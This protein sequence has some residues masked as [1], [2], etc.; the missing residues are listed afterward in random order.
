[1]GTGG[2]LAVMAVAFGG[3]GAFWA[4]RALCE[5]ARRRAQLASALATADEPPFAPLL[6]RG[7][8]PLVPLARRLLEVPGL[9]RAFEP[10]R[11]LAGA[12]GVDAD[13]A[14]LLSCLMAAMAVAGAA[15]GVV[16]ASPV[17]G[18]AVACCVAIAP[19][20][21][22]RTAA[23]RRALAMREEVPEA[24]RA[25]AVCFR[26]GL[27]LV[28]TLQQTAAE[29]GGA[30]GA[31]F[32]VAAQRL[33]MGA[34]SSEALE[35]LEADQRVPELRF[36][37]VALDVQ[38]QSGGSIGPVLESAQESVEGELD[39]LR[40]LKVQTAQ[41]KLSAKVVTIMPFVLVALFSFMSPGFLSPFFESLPGMAM[42]GLALVLEV[43]GVLA[44]R[45]MLR[46]GA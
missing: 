11:A 32:S 6:R 20:A 24:L 46:I 22:A 2:A 7:V 39:L 44:V 42:L 26:S 14:S 8:P 45:R 41:A 4:G 43:A 21:F 13:P 17:C 27:S 34:T 31:R 12:K 38:H 30:L 25:M 28:Q 23:E 40:S 16:S 36:V 10:V 29:L 19:V 15:A 5:A 3:A 18:A 1:M 9:A 33:E 37:A 35:A